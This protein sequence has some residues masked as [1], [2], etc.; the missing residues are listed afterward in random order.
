MARPGRYA[1]KKDTWGGQAS[2]SAET[3]AAVAEEE[4]DPSKRAPGRKDKKAYCKPAHGPHK[5]MPVLKSFTS[6]P[7]ACQW[8]LDWDC[9][10]RT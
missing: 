2:R 6:K 7:V 3:A 9:R 10:T 4:R 8:V 1:R 5:P